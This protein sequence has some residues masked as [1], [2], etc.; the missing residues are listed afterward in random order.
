MEDPEVT[1]RIGP[2]TT[3]AGITTRYS[4]PSLFLGQPSVNP[5]GISLANTRKKR[6]LIPPP[7]LLETDDFGKNIP[8]LRFLI[9]P[10][11]DVFKPS[12]RIIYCLHY[13]S[14]LESLVSEKLPR[15]KQKTSLKVL[16]FFVKDGY[17]FESRT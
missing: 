15:K 9:C 10:H 8:S 11:A 6:Y 1:N 2:S 7:P 3:S 4:T 16:A 14:V 5:C 17:I 13:V 12:K